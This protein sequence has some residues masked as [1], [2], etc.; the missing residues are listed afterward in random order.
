MSSK[1][2]NK[3]TNFPNFLTLLF[4]TIPVLLKLTLNSVIYFTRSWGGLIIG[5]IV[6]LGMPFGCDLGD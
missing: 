6:P 2:Q 3:V 5:L 4:I 1:S